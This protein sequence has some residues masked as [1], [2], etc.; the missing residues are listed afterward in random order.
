[1]SEKQDRVAV[2]TAS[3][4]ERKYGTRF[5]EIMGIASDARDAAEKASAQVAEL[6]GN[7]NQDEIFDRL[8]DGGTSQGIYRE[9]GII[10]IN[11]SFIKTGFI[12]SDIIKAGKIR[13]T[14]FEVIE[15]DEIFPGSTV[16]PGATMYP[17][18]GDDIHRGIEI[19]FSAGVIRGALHSSVTEQLASRIEALENAVFN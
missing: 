19:D 16:Y 4:L 9:N 7:L 11:A 6:D 18:N 5:A 2:R 3:D 10:Y 1:M 14:D 13:S 8:T 17:N 12:S 15:V